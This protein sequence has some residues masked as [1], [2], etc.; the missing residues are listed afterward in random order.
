MQPVIPF[1]DLGKIN[2]RDA[3]ELTE[4]FEAVLARGWYILGE[5]VEKFEKEFAEYIGVKEVV[6][7]ANGLDALTLTIRAWRELGEIEP[8]DEVIVP[9]NTYIATIL[10]IIE[11]RLH[12]ILVEPCI[13]SNNLDLS[14]LEACITTRT[15]AII[16]VHLYGRAVDLSS[17]KR[18]CENRHIKILEDVAQAHG[19]TIASRKAGSLGDAAAFSFY[20]GKNLGALGDGGA[21]TTDS[22]ELADVLRCLRN[23]GS[24]IKY[25]NERVGVNSRLDELQAALLRIKLLRLDSDNALRRNIAEFYDQNITNPC[26]RKPRIP[27]DSRS[28][29][30]HLYV[31]HTEKRDELQKYLSKHGVQTLIHYPIPPHKQTA[32]AQYQQLILPITEKLHAEAL[33][34]PISPVM[35]LRDAERVCAIVNSWATST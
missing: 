10:S 34:L 11:N 19:A 12:P 15:R 25:K 3:P 29:V 24:K 22:K 33:S 23:Y 35:E 1:L 5:E 2:N 30:W 16:A 20:P 26:I 28:H 9:A 13:E 8:G 6:G 21:V 4:R 18:L 27:E 32:L 17:I 31:I 14:T 7:V